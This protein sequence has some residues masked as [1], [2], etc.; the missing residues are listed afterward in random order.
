MIRTIEDVQSWIAARHQPQFILP[1]RFRKESFDTFQITDENPEHRRLVERARAF[2]ES[3]RPRRRRF[4]ERGGDDEGDG[5][6]FVGPPG[7]G[8]THLLAA[9]FVAADEPKLFATF[10]ELVAAAGPLG[11]T[12]LTEI[13]SAPDLVCIDEVVLEDPGNITMLATL[14][15]HMVGAGT[16][17]FATANMPPQEAGGEGGWMQSFERELG[18]IASAFD[19]VRIEGRDRRTDRGEK[20]T[21]AVGREGSELRLSWQELDQYLT[22]THPMHDAGW[23]GQVGCITLTTTVEPP[24]DKDRALRFIRFIDRVYD[25]DVELR[26]GANQPPVESFV[27]PLAGDKRYVW[28]VRR[29]VSRLSTLLQSP[30]SS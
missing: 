1:A 9:G 21:A 11:M 15:Q 8:K 18:G 2:V 28:H 23:L 12:R 6:F 30:G 27:D 25:R 19:I 16:H 26:F 20:A 3:A 17:V 4:W 29:G 13:V 5:L 10:D 7:V 14:L 24:D 22:R